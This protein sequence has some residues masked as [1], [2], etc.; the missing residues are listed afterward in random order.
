VNGIDS[1]VNITTRDYQVHQVTLPVPLAS[2]AADGSILVSIQRTNASTG[3]IVNE[4][5]LEEVTQAEPPECLGVKVTPYF[6]ET[7]GSLSFFGL[8]AGAQ[9]AKVEALNPRGEV[10]GCFVVDTAG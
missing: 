7:Y 9:E 10:V 8:P 2:Y 6:N 4:I 5:V 3:A 1:G